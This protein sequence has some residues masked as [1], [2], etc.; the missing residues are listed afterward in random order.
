MYDIPSKY[1]LFFKKQNSKIS[2]L[3]FLNSCTL[4]YLFQISNVRQLNEI[5]HYITK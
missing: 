1:V 4:D 2:S 5:F 3:G